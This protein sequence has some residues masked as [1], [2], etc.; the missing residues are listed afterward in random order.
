MFLAGLI[1]VGHI[2]KHD[3]KLAVE[4]LRA[5]MPKVFKAPSYGGTAVTVNTGQGAGGIHQEP[6]SW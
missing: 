4:M 3:N 6:Q 1:P 2:R 5:H